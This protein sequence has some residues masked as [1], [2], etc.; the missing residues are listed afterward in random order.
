MEMSL[1][2]TREM[3]KPKGRKLT[4]YNMLGNSDIEVLKSQVKRPRRRTF[5]THREQE[6][7]HK[8]TRSW[9]VCE[10]KKQKQY[11]GSTNTDPKQEV[12]ERKR[13][14]HRAKKET[15]T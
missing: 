5:R 6:T 14:G 8:G 15:P 4:P 12:K 1:H 11:A 2:P 7:G 9:G 13:T 3:S 10:G